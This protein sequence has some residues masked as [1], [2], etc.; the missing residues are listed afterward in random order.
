M[1]T[2]LAPGTTETSTIAVARVASSDVTNP[3]V[4]T[5]CEVGVQAAEVDVVPEFSDRTERCPTYSTLVSSEKMAWRAFVGSNP[6]S[7]QA[8]RRLDV[9]LQDV[10]L[11]RCHSFAA[12]LAAPRRLRG[13]ASNDYSHDAC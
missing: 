4:A 13:R 1:H 2:P 10:Y 3:N 9:H 5:M 8:R 7:A 11:G 12:Q 6:R